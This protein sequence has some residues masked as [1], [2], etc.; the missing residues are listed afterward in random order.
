MISVLPEL[1]LILIVIILFTIQILTELL[2][3][4]FAERLGVLIKF[5][6]QYF[7]MNYVIII[8][9]AVLTSLDLKRRPTIAKALAWLVIGFVFYFTNIVISKRGGESTLKIYNATVI[10]LLGVSLYFFYKVYKQNTEGKY[11]KKNCPNCLKVEFD[12]KSTLDPELLDSSDIMR[13]SGEGTTYSIWMK[14]DNWHY[15]AVSNKWKHVFH[16]GGGI[17]SIIN[18]N[19]PPDFT[20]KS[21]ENQCPGVWL[22]PNRNDVR[23]VFTTQHTEISEGFEGNT[24]S[25]SELLTVDRHAEI[26]RNKN[27]VSEEGEEISSE[28]NT[29]QGINTMLEYVQVNNIPVKKWFNLSI[30]VMNRNVDIYI[31]GLLVKSA[32]LV[33]LPKE[34]SGNIYFNY[35]GGFKGSRDIFRYIPK[36][37]TTSDMYFLNKTD[38]KNIKC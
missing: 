14:I 23:I 9:W 32:I 24:G 18:E 17:S 28:D 35:L 16:R 1:I 22:A 12:S 2:G 33:G 25:G 20:W 5:I 29:P 4:E 34:N 8:L 3:K 36:D 30:S 21:I 27:Q 31:N 19:R 15:R 13:G 7:K 26:H 38:K 10:I 37:T 11:D 6:K